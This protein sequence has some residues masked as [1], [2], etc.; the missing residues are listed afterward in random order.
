MGEAGRGRGRPASRPKTTMW[1]EGINA[2][3]LESGGPRGDSEPITAADGKSSGPEFG[4]LSTSRDA[5]PLRDIFFK[6]TEGNGGT[7][8]QVGNQAGLL[9]EVFGPPTCQPQDAW[10]SVMAMKRARNG[11]GDGPGAGFNSAAPVFVPGAPAAMGGAMPMQMPMGG[12]PGMAMPMPM[13]GMPMQG[14][15]MQG[16]PMQGMDNQGP[17]NFVPAMGYGQMGQQP[18]GPPMQG[19]AGDGQGMM[20]MGWQPQ[21]QMQG[22]VQPQMQQQPQQQPK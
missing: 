1:M 5:R 20:Q 6:L 21:M 19:Y 17:M 11:A 9:R 13:Q 22:Q 8:W 16:M 14:M 10:N 4:P 15:P 2:L 3:N 7:S 18:M 12:Y